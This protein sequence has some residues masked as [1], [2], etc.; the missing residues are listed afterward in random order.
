MQRTLLIGLDGMCFSILNPLIA[1]GAM[2]FLGQFMKGSVYADLISTPCP[3]TPPAWTTIMTGC[4]PGNHGIFD[5]ITVDPRYTDRIVFRLTNARDVLCETIWSIAG[6]QGRV[7][8]SLNFPQM[9][10]SKPF[11]GFMIPGF[12]TSR[13]LK[14][15]THPREF[16]DRIKNLSGVAIKDISWDLDE[17]R[18]PIGEGLEEE[19]HREWVNYLIRKEK[20]WSAI[21]RELIEG[22]SCDLVAVVF[23]GT[24]RLMHQAWRFID[25]AFM[26]PKPTSWEK[27]T[28]ER[29]LSYFRQLDNVVREL[30]EAAGEDSRVFIVSDHGL[31]PTTEIFYS[32]V[33]LE[34][35][36][37][38]YWKDGVRSDKKGLLTAFNLREHFDSIDWKKTVAYTRTTSA[39][40]IYIRVGKEPGQPG[41]APEQ[42]EVFRAELMK[43]LLSYKDPRTNMPV[44]T[45]IMTREEAFPGKAIEEAPDLTLTL[46][47]G[48]FV[49]ILKADEVVK[50]RQQIGGTHSP[51]GIFVARGKNIQKGLALPPQTILD[52]APTLLYAINLPIPEDFEGKVITEA[53]DPQFLRANPVRIGA[54]TIP[55]A[56][57]SGRDHADGLEGSDEREILERLKALGYLE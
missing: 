41:I 52:V 50:A 53:F 39:N 16:W 30:V 51:E 45:K 4:N 8:G 33:W 11:N 36:G 32:N 38:L 44:V 55:S 2:P 31:G 18:K 37:Y 22:T 7:V 48:G 3:V 6:R 35:G 43:S 23:E 28:R 57:V 27:E 12:V 17:G 25:P 26:P 40:G 19:A 1:D 42:Y 56:I 21:A 29:C 46:R 49:S 15:S 14:T 9:F 47:D 13:H 20:G 10:L 34:R 24:D 5:F 54:S